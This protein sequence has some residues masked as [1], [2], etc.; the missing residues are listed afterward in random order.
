MAIA[1]MSS[2]SA[3]RTHRYSQP[4]LA[5]PLMLPMVTPVLLGDAAN[6]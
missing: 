2:T 3:Y 5:I 6:L 1:F 4:F